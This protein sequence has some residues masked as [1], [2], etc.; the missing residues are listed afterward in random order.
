MD[1]RFEREALLQ[2]HLEEGEVGALLERLGEREFGGDPRPTVA[3]VIE[4]TGADPIEVGRL[5]AEIRGEAFERRFERAFAQ[6]TQELGDHEERIDKLE[7]RAA[8]LETFALRPPV[9]DSPSSHAREEVKPS[10]VVAP[11]NDLNE[12]SLA[13][14]WILAIGALVML[15]ILVGPHEEAKPPEPPLMGRPFPGWEPRDV[16]E[17]RELS[18][19][20]TRVKSSR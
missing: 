17:A 6:H 5:L 11:W 1:H 20:G 7:S 2:E 15:Y 14:Y 8:R 4:A 18:P 9:S 19:F 16:V 12:V 10:P 3:A 13:T